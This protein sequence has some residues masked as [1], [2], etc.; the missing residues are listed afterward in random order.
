LARN[1]GDGQSA[2]SKG[3]PLSRRR[4]WIAHAPLLT[5]RLLQ[6]V[7]TSS[8]PFRGTK[9]AKGTV[10]TFEDL[11]VPS[12]L[13]HRRAH[14]SVWPERDETKH[15]RLSARTRPDPP[16]TGSPA[17]PHLTQTATAAPC[18]GF[19]HHLQTSGTL[20]LALCAFGCCRR[21]HSFLFVLLSHPRLPP[22]PFAVVGRSFL[23]C[24]ASRICLDRSFFVLDSSNDAHGFP[25][26]RM[27]G[28]G[29]TFY[30]QA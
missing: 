29:T 12:R 7:T 19:L 8:S 9:P 23:L 28:R 3:G 2:A 30:P 17:H 15:A 11:F 24:L 22:L 4:L 14:H 1:G 18:C 25:C 13:N 5:T 27:L 20:R 10:W 16:P 6:R 26:T 21:R